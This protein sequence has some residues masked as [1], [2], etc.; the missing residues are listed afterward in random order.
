MY[1][2][3]EF[4]IYF[5]VTLRGAPGSPWSYFKGTQEMLKRYFRNLF[6]RPLGMVQKVPNKY[7]EMG[8]VSFSDQI[9]NVFKLFY[10]LYLNLH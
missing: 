4:D 6:W 9:V 2:W 3:G 1:S 8:Y 5:R 10:I 7:H